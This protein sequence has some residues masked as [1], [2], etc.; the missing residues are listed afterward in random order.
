MN[1][2]M[3]TGKPR[4][5][6]LLAYHDEI[7]FYKDMVGKDLGLSFDNYNECAVNF[8]FHDGYAIEVDDDG[9]HIRPEQNPLILFYPTIDI[10]QKDKGMQRAIEDYTCRPC[11][12][13]F[14]IA[15]KFGRLTRYRNL[16]QE[17]KL[18]LKDDFLSEK[19]QWYVKC[20]PD[21]RIKHPEIDQQIQDYYNNYQ[22]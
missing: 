19:L 16:S 21:Y 7:L 12:N 15:L 11:K 8:D 17:E 20:C 9:N 10:V 13:Q 2:D 3:I 18:S 4:Q 6:T 14:D 5:R 22:L 1:K